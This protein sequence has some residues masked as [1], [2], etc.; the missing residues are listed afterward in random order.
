MTE[1]RLLGISDA[2]REDIER[3]S[4]DPAAVEACAADLR[5]VLGTFPGH[6]DLKPPEDPRVS[7]AAFLATVDDVRAYHRSRGVS[8][9][10]SWAT[11]A[12][13]GRHLAIHRRTHGEFGLETHWWI[14]NSWTGVLYQL[15]RLQ[16]LLHQPDHEVPG[17]EP[18]EWIIGVHIP[19]TGPL[20][21]ALI[22][23]SLDQARAF[24]A[25]HFPEQP[26]R[27][28]NLV[29][30][31]LDPYLLDHLPPASNTVSFGRRFTPY[32]EAEDSQESAVYFTFRTR[33]LGRLDELP[34]D[35]ALQRL[36]LDRI[37]AGGTWQ[38]AKGYLAL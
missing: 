2:D 19:E 36:I 12:D 15:G 32:G 18:G 23:E 28:A 22:D 14:A 10:V 8:D 35:T 9:E 5:R 27:T 4:L 7:I 25:E 24:F 20:T 16:F 3:L 6:G 11:L 30:W 31:L 26:V 21:P 29:S 38:T 1:Y 37:A 33:D 13:L 34:R 17:V